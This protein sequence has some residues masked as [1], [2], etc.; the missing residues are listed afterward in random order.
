MIKNTFIIIYICVHIH[1]QIR[2]FNTTLNYTYATISLCFQ[3]GPVTC[4][5]FDTDGGIPL[6]CLCN[7]LV[8]FL[9]LGFAD[10]RM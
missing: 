6:F 3:Q 4:L 1:L 5:Y 10:E 2:I 9:L 7:V 8:F